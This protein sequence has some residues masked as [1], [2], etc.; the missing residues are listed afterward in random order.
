MLSRI[1]Y[2]YGDPTLTSPR[3]HRSLVVSLTNAAR[4][5]NFVRSSVSIVPTQREIRSSSGLGAAE[6]SP[7]HRQ[8]QGNVEVPGAGTSTCSNR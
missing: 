4:L 2:R 7:S 1:N 5:V 3:L 8:E 6:D